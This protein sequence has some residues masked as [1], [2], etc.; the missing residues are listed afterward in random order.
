[1][2]LLVVR[3]EYEDDGCVFRGKCVVACYRGGHPRR[4]GGRGMVAATPLWW[5]LNRAQSLLKSELKK[6]RPGA[7]RDGVLMEQPEVTMVA[8]SM[9]KEL[10]QH[11]LRNSQMA[12]PEEVSTGQPTQVAA[13]ATAKTAK[14]LLSVQK[15]TRWCGCM[16]LH[17][18]SL[19]R[20]HCCRHQS[21]CDILRQRQHQRWRQ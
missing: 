10:R 3:R 18:E 1:M 8:A 12:R 4:A 15:E 19:F 21:G 14:S 11:G 9:A 7:R 20:I 5:L 6:A 13:A 17:A 2:L 16:P